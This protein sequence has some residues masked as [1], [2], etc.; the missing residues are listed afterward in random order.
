MIRYHVVDNQTGA[1][2]QTMSVPDLDT[3]TANLPEGSVPVACPDQP[4]DIA[5]H[6]WNKETRV[7]EALPPS[8]DALIERVKTKRDRIEAGGCQTPLGKRAQ[9]DADSQ[10]KISGLV[11]MA[12]LAKQAGADFAVGFTFADNATVTLD[13]DQMIALGVTVGRHVAACH[14]V[15]I[16]KRDLIADATTVGDM[17]TVDIDTGWPGA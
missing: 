16:K 4:I 1:I 7:Y 5:T 11:T 6:R 10:R 9:T 3:L 8:R 12:M 15:A 14:A 13:A 2:L 17:L